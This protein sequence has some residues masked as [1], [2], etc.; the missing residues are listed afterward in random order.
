MLGMQ[1]QKAESSSIG[2]AC[3]L[4]GI[5]G[6]KCGVS[7]PRGTEVKVGLP[8]HGT[9]WEVMPDRILEAEGRVGEGGAGR[10]GR[11]QGAP[12]SPAGVEGRQGTG[13][14]TPS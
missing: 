10:V 3:H 6:D 8:V 5:Q 13:L 1:M 4:A 11:A 2:D 9:G 7:L 14:H 12:S